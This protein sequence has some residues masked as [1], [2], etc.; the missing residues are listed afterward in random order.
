MGLRHIFREGLRRRGVVSFKLKGQGN[1]LQMGPRRPWDEASGPVCIQ[2]IHHMNTR[3]DT[4]LVA[5]RCARGKA[6]EEERRRG[7]GPAFPNVNTD[8]N[9][10]CPALSEKA[11]P[12]LQNQGMQ[13]NPVL[14]LCHLQTTGSCKQQRQLKIFNWLD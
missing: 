8:G 14:E 3:P 5:L 9:H 4:A 10:L 12:L 7:E 2:Q 6:E 13:T 11:G 1:E